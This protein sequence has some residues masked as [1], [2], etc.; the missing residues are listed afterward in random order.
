[1]RAVH[2]T[3][4]VG[5]DGVV[6]VETD[7]PSITDDTYEVEM[8]CAGVSFPDLLQTRGLY[9]IRPDPPFPAGVEGS[10]VIRHAPAGGAHR[11]GDPVM[12]WWPGALA[13]RLV[14]PE[15]AL[16]ALPEELDFAQGAGF[17]LNYQTAMFCL[18]HRGGLRAGET[19]LVLGASGGVGTA[20]VQVARGCGASL[21]IG[22]VSHPDKVDAVLASGA[23]HCVVISDHWR[24]EVTALTGGTGVDL[25]YDPV[26]GDRF[27][28]GLRCL[29]RFGRLVVV[30]F[31]AGEI[32]SIKVNRLLLRNVSVIGAAWG[33]AIALDRT[34]PARLH[35]ELMP[36][37]RDGGLRPV[38]GHIVDLASVAEAYRLIDD[39]AAI[40]KV[41]VRL[42]PDPVRS[43]LAD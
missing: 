17:I 22:L 27:L 19:V 42:R 23:H 43:P 6:V 34:L 24:D 29:A 31:A 40:G 16:F 12:V 4:L 13:E 25:V 26:G 38:V 14:V 15:R 7:P 28:D 39:R 21:V 10:G 32:P 33:E 9:Q 30:G 37:V 5:P 20:A 8:V 36:L 41:V 2:V 3:D 18:V 35:E 11:P 1:M